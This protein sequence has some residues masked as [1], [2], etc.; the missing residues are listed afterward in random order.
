MFYDIVGRIGHHRVQST[1][2]ILS[3]RGNKVEIPCILLI[4]HNAKDG[5][6]YYEKKNYK[7]CKSKRWY[8]FSSLLDRFSSVAQRPYGNL[9]RSTLLLADP[10][11]A[12]SSGQLD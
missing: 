3:P 12:P 7:S 1:Q 2:G 10:L 8:T 4:T 5:F 6:Y 11:I 9:V